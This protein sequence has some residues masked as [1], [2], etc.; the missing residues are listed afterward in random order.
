M[1]RPVSATIP[2]QLGREEARRRIAEGFGQVE[3]QLAGG[4][5][6]AVS[7]KEQWEGDRLVFEGG[8]FGQKVTGR[9]D[10]LADCV[11]VEVDLPEILAAIAER[12]VGK[13]KGETQKLLEKK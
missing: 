7:F 1:A 8:A 3:R 9:V 10:V 5:L 11:K 4:M 13:I 12:V 2:H 6:A